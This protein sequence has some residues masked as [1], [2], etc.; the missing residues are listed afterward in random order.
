[1]TSCNMRNYQLMM[2][3]AS[4]LNVLLMKAEFTFSHEKKPRP[5]TAPVARLLFQMM[6]R[7]T[8]N[9]DLEW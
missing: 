8:M 2:E 9:T 1:M 7:I 3:N 6:C 4:G 5:E